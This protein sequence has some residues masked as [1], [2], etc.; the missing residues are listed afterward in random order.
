VT[1]KL[2]VMYAGEASF[3]ASGYGTYAAE[4]MKRLHASDKYELVEFGSYGEF[5]DPRA[6]ALPWRF[7][8]NVPDP[9][10]PHEVARYNACTLNQF[11]LW[12][13]DE[14]CLHVKPDVVYGIRDWWMDE[15]Q[16]RSVFRDFF[17]WAIMPPVDAVPQNEE[18]LATYLTADAVLGYTDWAL[19]VLRQ[20]TGGRVRAAGVA[21]PGADTEL[22]RPFPRKALFKQAM[23]LPGDALVVGTTNRNQRRKLYPDL[24][25]TFA[26]L[27]NE[28]PEWLARRAYLYCHTS[29]PDVGWDLP[30]L[31]TEAGIGHRVFFTYLCKGCGAAY[32]SLYCDA[33]TACRQCGRPDAVLPDASFGVERATLAN[34]MNLFDVY[35]QPANSEG[36][37][38]GQV[39]AAACGVPVLSVDYSAMADVVRKLGGVPVK[40]A[41]LQREVETGCVRAVPDCDDLAE[42]LAA[43]LSLPDD[44]R[45]A[46]GWRHRE[47]VLRHFTYDRAAAAWMACFDS[48]KPRNLWKSPPRLV[49]PAPPVPPNLTNEEFVQWG[50]THVAGR[51]DLVGS[52]MH[53]RLVRDLN[54]GLTKEGMGGLAFSDASALGVGLDPKNDFK[55]FTRD[56]VLKQLKD[57]ADRHN[58]WEQR[59]IQ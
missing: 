25:E 7:I 17:H 19:D 1:Q 28:G 42:K 16:G 9:R 2:R 39:E 40:V 49:K 56:I 52:H 23:G 41:K 55:K 45:A 48:L 50:I 38:M 58:L 47:A 44:V 37:G 11:G 36:F 54:W 26:R 3:L 24:F 30:R 32:P 27:L 13:F 18:W 5:N 53:Y 57:I 21:P 15:H 10:D 34:V 6:R 59:R 14:V 22:F 35:V 43:V 31:L 51:P 8:S 46:W 12:R 33:R 20:A 29:Y 4:V